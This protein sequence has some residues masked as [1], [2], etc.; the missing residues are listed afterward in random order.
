MQFSNILR[1]AAFAIVTLG[2]AACGTTGGNNYQGTNYDGAVSG[3]VTPEQSNVEFTV[4]VAYDIY[5][6]FDENGNMRPAR[7][8]TRTES[9]MLAEVE[10]HCAAKV[11]EV[12]R[13][14]LRELE[15]GAFFSAVGALTYA[16]IAEAIPGADLANNMITG[17]LAFTGSSVVTSQTMWDQALGVYYSTCVS[18]WVA[19]NKAD[20]GDR[21]LSNILVSPLL[22]GRAPRPDMGSGETPRR[23]SD[24]AEWDDLQQQESAPV[25][26]PIVPM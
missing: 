7:A 25:P 19:A 26:T 14:A 21:R 18:N 23:D 11:R 5:T 9:V 2:L 3:Q 12:E 20:M 24:D 1:G 13:V 6:G 15:S 16:A 4:G 22:R 17:G 10:V 8:L